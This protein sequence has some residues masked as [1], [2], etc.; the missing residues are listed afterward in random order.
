[1]ADIYKFTHSIYTTN[2]FK[3]YNE[4]NENLETE[5]FSVETEDNLF[6]MPVVKTRDSEM[7]SS[8][9]PKWTFD[10]SLYTEEDFVENYGNPMASVNIYRP[11]VVVTKD[12]KK[13]AIKFFEYQ[14]TRMRGKPYFRV[15]TKVKYITF[16]YITHSLY[17]G[18]IINYHKK[19]KFTKR[20]KRNCF[21][22][23]SLN[24]M[25][26]V[27][28]N[29]VRFVLEKTPELLI[30]NTVVN[31]VITHF[32]DNIPNTEKYKMYT[33]NE[34]LFKLYLDGHKIKSPNNWN[35]F[36]NIYP[37]PKKKDYVKHKLKFMDAFMFIHGLQGDKIKRVL[38]KVTDIKGLEF[39]KF[40]N[41]FFGKEFMAS[42][43]DKLIQDIVECNLYINGGMTGYLKNLSK[44]EKNNSFEVFKQVLRGDVDINTYYDHFRMINQLRQF[45]PVKWDAKDY[46]SFTNEHMVLSDKISFYTKG[47]FERIYGEEFTNRVQEPLNIDGVTYYPVLLKTSEEYNMESFIQSNCVKGYV[48][49]AP[50]L[51]ISFREGSQDSKVRAT[52]EF[53]ISEENKLKRIQTLG[54]FNKGLDDEWKKPLIMLDLKI[55]KLMSAK[56][57]EL[58][59]VIL[60]IGYKEFK[61]GS[62]FVDKPHYLFNGSQPTKVLDWEDPRIN[63]RPTSNYGDL[64]FPQILEEP[65][66]LLE[67]DLD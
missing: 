26:G 42:Q 4:Y 2:M 31:D 27:L 15:S 14:R 34:V 24:G 6:D 51:I 62:H 9:H 57:F 23:G 56:L 63:N 8:K 28:S 32:I 3:N 16:N 43:D 49:R 18:H 21:Y 35:T 11:T 65:L 45:E 58:P 13:V 50:S 55:G 64:P 66:P 61:S 10:K 22:D 12:D 39:F 30:N 53:T 1:M 54:R 25:L 59:G 52:I 29:M 47:T 44:R 41:D 46:D 17:S 20:V 37:Q 40:T 33:P 36:V 19:R 67:N 38:H 5:E 7:Y 60:K 48:D